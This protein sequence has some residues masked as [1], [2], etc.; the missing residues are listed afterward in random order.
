MCAYLAAVFLT[1][2]AYVATDAELTDIWRRRALINGAV[3]G[4]LALAGLFFVT[5]DSPLLWTGFRE[6]SWMF[7]AASVL[8]GFLSLAALW[9]RLFRWAGIG[10]A[11]TVATV[12][13]GWAAAQ[14][15][16]LVP[17]AITIASAKADAAVLRIVA[18]SITGGMLLLVP[19]LAYLLY[20]FKTDAPGTPVKSA[21]AS[22][23]PDG[24]RLPGGR[25]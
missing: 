10:A 5:S 17:P 21:G 15:P 3:L 25:A 14:S 23:G 6:R 8:T 20:L 22:A 2:E 13:W 7:V 1:R 4:F 11:A 24:G 18:T 9:C 12:I 19:A 16:W